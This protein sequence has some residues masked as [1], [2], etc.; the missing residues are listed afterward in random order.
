MLCLLCLIACSRR[1]EKMG[2]VRPAATPAAS[3]STQAI[4]HAIIG[5][6]TYP[7]DDRKGFVR[8]FRPD[9]SMT[10]WWPDGKIAGE[11]TYFVV[12]S[13]T[14]GVAYPNKDTDM[15]HLTD[16]DTIQVAHVQYNGYHMKYTGRRVAETNRP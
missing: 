1:E 6:W 4:S 5:T 16:S 12:D 10:V 3:I 11:G 2:V 14:V 15:V 7:I 13:N 8:T 9:G